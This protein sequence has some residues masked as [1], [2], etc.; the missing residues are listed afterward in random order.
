MT[1]SDT[2]AALAAHRF[3]LGE[4]NLT[5]VGGDARAW[6][7]AQIGPAEPQRGNGLASGVEG[8]KRFAEFL[9]TQRRPGTAMAAPIAC[10]WRCLLPP[11]TWRRRRLRTIACSSLSP[12]TIRA[13]RPR[14]SRRA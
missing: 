5:V 9:A 10:L 2:E 6:L 13:I 3:G 4:P 1:R 8:V 12:R 7:L 11:A 14:K